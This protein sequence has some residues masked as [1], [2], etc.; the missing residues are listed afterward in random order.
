MDTFIE[1]ELLESLPLGKQCPPEEVELI[2]YL[3]ET[4]LKK[5]N[6]QIIYATAEFH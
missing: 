3:Y 1:R 5:V 4:K 2:S 6:S